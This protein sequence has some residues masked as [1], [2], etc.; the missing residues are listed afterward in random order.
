MKES[1]M[2]EKP[3]AFTKAEQT[4]LS[5]KTPDEYVDLCVKA[6]LSPRAK[7]RLAKEWMKQT[8]FVVE[9][10]VKA[11]NRHPYWKAKKQENSAERTKIRM[12]VHNYSDGRDVDWSDERVAEFLEKNKKDKDGNYVYRDWQLAEHFKAT[13]PSIQY[14]RRKLIRLQRVSGEGTLNRNK[15][16]E[17]MKRSEVVLKKAE[18]GEIKLSDTKPVKKAAAKKPAAK[19][20]AAKKP[21]AKKVAAKKPAAKKVAAKKPAAKKVAAKK[22]AAK[23]PAKKVAAKKPAAKKVAAKKPAAKKAPAKKP[24]A[25]KAPVA[26]KPVVST[27]VTSNDTPSSSSLW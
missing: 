10:I 17:S 12:S 25:K 3:L 18:K 23:K 24:A 16:V 1:G 20:V 22:V 4:V 15:L 2:K 7:A 13:I 6:K 8:G 5:A 21:A 11:R 19:K 26:K 27:P 14:M 9:S